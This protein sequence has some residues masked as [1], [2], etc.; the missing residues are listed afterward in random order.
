MYAICEIKGKQYKVETGKEYRVD[1]LN[2][3]ENTNY[4][5]DKVLLAKNDDGEVK[6]GTP[7]IENAKVITKVV[8]PLIKGEKVYAFKY[9]RR[10]GFHK[11]IGHRQKYSVIK[12]EKI[13]I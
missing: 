7:Y 2:L 8:N 13:E 12:V 9:K 4:E 5:V 1:L 6:I 10:K 11:K 3:D